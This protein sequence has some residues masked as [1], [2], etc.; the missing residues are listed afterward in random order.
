VFRERGYSLK[1]NSRC[2][3]FDSP[4]VYRITVQGRLAVCWA[5]S[6]AGMTIRVR[7]EKTKSATTTLT[8]SLVDQ[9]R[10]IA[11]LTE[12]YEMGCTLLELKRLPEPGVAQLEGAE[13]AH[14]QLPG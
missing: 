9:A 1:T 2:L 5:D 6:F 11:L 4:G 10:L 14:S 13:T 12:L 8:G 3:L 7:Q